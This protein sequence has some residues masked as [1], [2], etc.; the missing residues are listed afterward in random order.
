M[1]MAGIIDFAYRA[2][3]VINATVIREW[4]LSII[5]GRD[6]EHAQQIAVEGL[7]DLDRG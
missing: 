4:L 1:S 6:F 7:E 2:E 3:A 5:A